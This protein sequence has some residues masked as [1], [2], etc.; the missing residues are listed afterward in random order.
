MTKKKSLKEVSKKENILDSIQNS[1]QEKCHQILEG[2]NK[3]YAD[4][5]GKKINSLNK[6]TNCGIE[7]K[8]WP[9]IDS[10]F[11]A[12]LLNTGYDGTGGA[13][14]SGAGT[15]LQWET[16]IGNAT[17]VGSVNS[18]IP[19]F[20][21]RNN[22]W[23][24]SPFNNANWISYYNNGRHSGNVI[25]YFRVRFYLNSS[26]NPSNFALNMSFLADNSVNDIYVNG[27]SQAANHPTLLPQEQGSSSNSYNFRGFDAG[28]GINIS[29]S[30]DWKECENEIIVRVH[31]GQNYAGFL[32]QN[33]STCYEAQ[34]P[35]YQPA[36]AIKWGDR[37]S[38]CLERED[39]QT[40]CLTVCNNYS[41]IDFKNFKIGKIEICH[42]NGKPVGVLSTGKP[43]VSAI[44]K[45]PFCFGD[46]PSCSCVSREFLIVNRGAKGGKYKIKVSGICYDVCLNHCNEACFELSICKK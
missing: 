40:M 31:S 38:D 19:A 3:E 45:G 32:A 20:V 4:K 17:G 5:C 39:C 29:L 43:S 26:I 15:D 12:S 11:D 41:N 23:A 25:L 24:S 10:K 16:G 13:I 14:A 44:P 30:H 46:I 33:T 21:Y 18:W 2:L 37:K 6:C 9:R 34:I 42:E 22:A 35:E 8:G 1:S 7:N 27:V 36:I 28:K